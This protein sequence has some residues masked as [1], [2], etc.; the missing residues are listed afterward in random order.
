M[1]EKKYPEKGGTKIMNPQKEEIEKSK[2][3]GK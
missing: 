2:K 1:V 3:G